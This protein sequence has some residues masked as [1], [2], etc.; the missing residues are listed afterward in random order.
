MVMAAVALAVVQAIM[1]H[2]TIQ[3]TMRYAHL[4]PN[5]LHAGIA[6]LDGWHEGNVIQQAVTGTASSENRTTGSR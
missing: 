2:K 6:V 5:H 1:G 4:S 3:T